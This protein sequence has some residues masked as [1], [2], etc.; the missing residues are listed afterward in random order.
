MDN[1]TRSSEIPLPIAVLLLGLTIGGLTIGINTR[2]WEN[3]A[4]RI[5]V[6]VNE[7]PWFAAFSCAAVVLNGLA[8]HVI[9]QKWLSYRRHGRRLRELTGEGRDDNLRLIAKVTV[10]ATLSFGIWA[11]AL[12]LISAS[13]IEVFAMPAIVFNVLF[14]NLAMAASVIIHRLWRLWHWLRAE[15][16]AWASLAEP[17]AQ[18]NQLILGTRFWEAAHEKK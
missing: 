7:N 9:I 17:P 3:Y 6:Y 11:A 13:A 4:V 2:I 16:L 5:D 12:S 18:P 10:I 8:A 15:H 14:F 1:Q